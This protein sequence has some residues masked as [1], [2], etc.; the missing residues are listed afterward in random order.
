MDHGVAILFAV[1]EEVLEVCA[2]GPLGRV[3]DWGVDLVYSSAGYAFAGS[4]ACAVSE[5]GDGG[6]EGLARYVNEAVVVKEV[7]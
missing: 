4:R 1:A 3:Q 6:S 5:K 7:L 2:E